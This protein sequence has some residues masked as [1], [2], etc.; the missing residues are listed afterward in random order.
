[1]KLLT[2]CLVLV[3]LGYGEAIFDR[4]DSRGFPVTNT[5]NCEAPGGS[6]IIADLDP[7]RNLILPLLS[8]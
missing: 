8:P 6:P 3:V 4:F 1:M 7:Q 5:I 2:V